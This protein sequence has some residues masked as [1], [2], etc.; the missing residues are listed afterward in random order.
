MN[1]AKVVLTAKGERWVRGG[2]PWVFR[3]DIA[4]ME[5]PE[6]GAVAPFFNLRGDFLGQGFY[7]RYSRI[8][9]R[10]ISSGEEVVDEAYW[11]RTLQQACRAREAYLEPR[12]QACRVV[13]SEAD[14]LPGLIADWY[15]GN[16]V[17]QTLIPGTERLLPLFSDL[18]R[19]L[20]EPQTIF[21]R[22]DSDAR[23]LEKLS[24]ETR[25][26]YRE[27]PG[28]VVVREGAVR[29]RVDLQGGQK[30]GAY[31]DQQEN[32]KGL[33]VYGRPGIRVLD[34]FCYTG[35]FAL[36]QA[37]KAGEVTAVDD[38]AGAVAEGLENARLNGL[39]NVRFV[40]GNVFDF[41]KEAEKRGERFDLIT[42]DPPPFARRKSEI[43]G[44]QR[45]YLEL[46]RRALSI[47]NPGGFLAT[48]SCSHHISE[49]FF[50]DILKEA[51][52]KTGRRVFLLEKQLQARDHP[53]LITFPESYYLKGLV[54]RV[55]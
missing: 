27:I 51:A 35:G 52:Q 37:L 1:R 48:Y 16:L 26:L 7:S 5:E 6:N 47:L 31:L 42:L 50:L 23:K 32:R 11:R 54:A 33:T 18:F 17:L 25:L 53:I 4:Q 55:E 2:H 14:G 34:C 36:H 24:P 30:T 13:F 45:G 29:Y 20:L 40:K 15:A 10:K 46:N 49:A 28:K 38:S 8:A 43:A 19:E 3:D 39:G 44:G 21:L 22:N 41:L 9:L 12:D